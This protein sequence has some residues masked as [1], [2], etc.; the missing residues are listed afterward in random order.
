MQ[1][2]A[3][4]ASSAVAGGREAAGEVAHEGQAD[5]DESNSPRSSLTNFNPSGDDTAETSDSIHLELSSPEG[6]DAHN[7]GA[8]HA[9][10]EHKDLTGRLSA[11]MEYV[12]KQGR[13]RKRLT[14]SE[15]NEKFEKTNKDNKDDDQDPPNKNMKV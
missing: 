7:N 13:S 3:G 15:R 2:A 12:K 6:S 4:Q 9:L 1:E 5:S 10:I 14:A 8:D 11:L